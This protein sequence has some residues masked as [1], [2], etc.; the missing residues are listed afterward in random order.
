MN[1]SQLCLLVSP[2]MDG[3]SEIEM[4]TSS[5]FR[6][7]ASLCAAAHYETGRLRPGEKL[8]GCITPGEERFT[9]LPD[10]KCLLSFVVRIENQQG[11]Q[12][13]ACDFTRAVLLDLV[14][15]SAFRMI[16]KHNNGSASEDRDETDA[17]GQEMRYCLHF[18]EEG[19]PVEPR[20]KLPLAR[21]A[22]IDTLRTK[23][24]RVTTASKDSMQHPGVMTTFLRREVFRKLQALAEWSEQSGLEEGCFLD[25]EVLYDPTHRQFARFITEFIPASGAEKREASLRIN[26][27]CW[28]HYHK[29]RTGRGILLAEGHSHPSAILSRRKTDTTIF[30]SSNDKDI[31]RQFFWQF[32]QST[33][34]L[35]K[36]ETQGFQL[37]IWGWRN[38]FIVPEHEAF[39]IDD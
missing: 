34:I 18:V 8:T 35:S 10:T 39:V 29:S 25:G 32:F 22:D 30:M 37:G 7:Y 23:S 33:V 36:P 15:A 6:P 5:D 13:A 19:V 9:D 27:D 12:V 3:E 1:Q 17:P 14:E 38:G 31:H 28:S 4:L 16:A 20:V 2:G 21:E 11:E 24:E 26:G